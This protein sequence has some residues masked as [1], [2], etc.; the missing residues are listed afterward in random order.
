MF[1]KH[2]EAGEPSRESGVK[3]L[4]DVSKLL[5]KGAAIIVERGHDQSHLGEGP[6]GERCALCSLIEA[7]GNRFSRTYED[8]KA[9]LRGAV[10]E[11]ITDWNNQSTKEEV[12]A[13][14][15]AVAL[16]G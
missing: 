8:A 1:V 15:R 5:L 2:K 14:L 7:D 10:G 3:P 9:R 11:S 6:N 16:G 12:V 13:K 4:D